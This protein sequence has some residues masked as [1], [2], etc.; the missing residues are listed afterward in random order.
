METI[1]IKINNKELKNK[2]IEVLS[3]VDWE[4]EINNT[5]TIS[6]KKYHII[7]ILKKYIPDI[8]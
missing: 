8:S 6:I 5:V 4:K 7:D 2:I 1:N 3:N